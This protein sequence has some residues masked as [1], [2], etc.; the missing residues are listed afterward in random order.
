M[1]LQFR[2]EPPTHPKG[3][4]FGSRRSRRAK[5]STAVAG[6][7]IKEVLVHLPKSNSTT[8]GPQT[9]ISHQ[10]AARGWR[11]SAE[12]H[13][14]DGER[15]DRRI[16]DGDYGHAVSAHVQLRP[17]LGRHRRRDLFSD[18]SKVSCC[19]C[20]LAVMALLGVG[21]WQATTSAS[22][23]RDLPII[24]YGA[25]RRRLTL[26]RCAHLST[27]LCFP[28]RHGTRGLGSGA[29]KIEFVD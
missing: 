21:S 18:G 2:I 23:Y 24:I 14:V 16:V 22:I 17:P 19:R 15:V 8:R 10:P 26:T 27:M 11:G 20:F 7:G 4:N 13:T 6:I 5:L 9:P 1:S 12:Y 29:A 25:Y 28:R 3:R